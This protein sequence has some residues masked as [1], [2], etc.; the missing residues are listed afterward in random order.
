[1]TYLKGTDD[2]L[3]PREIALGLGKRTAS[4][5]SS[6]RQILHRMY[7]RGQIIKSSNG[8]YLHCYTQKKQAA[9]SHSQETGCRTSPCDM[10]HPAVSSVAVAHSGVADDDLP[11]AEESKKW[12]NFRQFGNFK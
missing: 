10:S 6:L 9:T 1:M 8:S 2:P 4:E 7:E 5:Q 12:S 11:V 3:F